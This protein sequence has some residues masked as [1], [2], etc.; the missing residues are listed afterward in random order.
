LRF[1]T[2][3]LLLRDE[4]GAGAGAGAP[5]LLLLGAAALDEMDDEEDEEEEDDIPLERGAPSRFELLSAF[6]VRRGPAISL[7]RDPRHA[8]ACLGL[9]RV[10]HPCRPVAAPRN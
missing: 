5:P 1:D 7:S 8:A 6:V 3:A 9:G 4:A 2:R 10:L